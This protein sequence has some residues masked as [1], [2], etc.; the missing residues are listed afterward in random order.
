MNYIKYKETEVQVGTM[1]HTYNPATK[2]AESR[3]ITVQS[4]PWQSVHETPSKSWGILVFL[5]SRL[6]RK[7]IWRI[8][9]QASLDINLRCYLEK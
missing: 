4:Q 8:K 6:L 2:E 3:R 5:S 1:A 7:P 9:I